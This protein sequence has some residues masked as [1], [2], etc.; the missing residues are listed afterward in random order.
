M[1]ETYNYVFEKVKENI[2]TVSTL[3]ACWIKCDQTTVINTIAQISNLV[4]KQIE[5]ELI[6][7]VTITNNKGNSNGSNG[8][9]KT[10]DSYS[11]SN[12]NRAVMTRVVQSFEVPAQTMA[13]IAS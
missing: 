11:S 5:F 3:Y 12:S 13:K 1:N 10:M 8:N 4:L 2:L 6:F 9:G 7:H